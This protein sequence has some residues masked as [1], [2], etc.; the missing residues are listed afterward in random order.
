MRARA[1]AYLCATGGSGVGAY[2]ASSVIALVKLQVVD[3]IRRRD[4]Y[5]ANLENIALTTGASEGVKRCLAAI[6]SNSNDGVMIPCPQYPLY[7]ASITMYGGKSIYYDLDEATSWKITRASLEKACQENLSV[8]VRS[9]A[10]INPGNPSRA[11]LDL[12]DIE[13]IIVFSFEKNLVI[14]ADEVYQEK[15][16]REVVPLLQ[17]GAEADAGEGCQVQPVAAHL[18]GPHR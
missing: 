9:I 16:R 14:L 13:M 2:T 17:E 6:I 5:P 4:G 18:Q 15:G 1:Q 10:V 7:S 8:N 11:V 12:S 3:F